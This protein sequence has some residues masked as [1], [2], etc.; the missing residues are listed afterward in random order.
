[1][2]FKH[3]ALMAALSVSSSL[4]LVCDVWQAKFSLC[5]RLFNLK[6]LIKLIP[7]SM[8]NHVAIFAKLNSMPVVLFGDFVFKTVIEF[9]NGAFVGG[10]R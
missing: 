3:T 2:D 5:R 6:T 8:H 7:I 4:Y 9:T 1:M 10:W